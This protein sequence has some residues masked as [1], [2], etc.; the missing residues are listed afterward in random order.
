MVFFFLLQF[1]NWCFYSYQV[2]GG[3]SCLPITGWSPHLTSKWTCSSKPPRMSLLFT[4]IFFPGILYTDSSASKNN[5]YLIPTRT[6]HTSSPS[7]KSPQCHRALGSSTSHSPSKPHIDL[8]SLCHQWHDVP[9]KRSGVRSNYVSSLLPRT[10]TNER[11]RLY[12]IKPSR[13]ARCSFME[14]YKR[15][16]EW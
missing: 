7:A 1:N 9:L 14:F 3:H 4:H 12:M 6:T 11:L 13:G 8:S 10:R 15:K 5:N 2:C 16:F